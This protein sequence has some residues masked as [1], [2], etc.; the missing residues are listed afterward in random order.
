M[1]T[2]LAFLDAL[3]AQ[4]QALSSAQLIFATLALVTTTYLV[5]YVVYQR[6]FHPLAKFPGPFCASITNFWKVYELSTLAL[7]TRM[8][9]VHEKYGPVVRI[10]PDDLSFNIP[11]AIAPIYKVGRK[12]P[13]GI[14]Y[15]GY[16]STVPD[17]FST[18]DENVSCETPTPGW[19]VHRTLLTNEFNC[20]LHALRLKQIGPGLSV[21]ALKH[22]EPV[23]DN[24]IDKLLQK[25]DGYVESGAVLD[26]KSALGLYGYDVTAQLAF[27]TDFKAQTTGELPPLN[28][29]F[30][31]GNIYGL[32]ANLLPHIA[33]WSAYL[34]QVK[35]LIQSRNDLKKIAA[36]SI[37]QSLETHNNETE[38]GTLLAAL[39][40]A[41]DPDSGKGLTENEINSEAFVFLVAGSHTT[42]SAMVALLFYI[43]QNPKVLARVRAELDSAIPGQQRTPYE[44]TGL[45][46][47]L[48]YILACIRESFRMSPTAALL[49]P[50]EVINPAGTMIGDYHVPLGA[51]CS[52]L[53]TCLHH[54]PDVWGSDH[55]QFDPDRFLPGSARYSSSNPNM[56]F[57]FGQGNRQ[58]A[59]R[60]IALMSIWKVVVT[61]MKNY[62]IELVNPNE[63]FVML[64]YGVG[65]KKGPMNVRVKRRIVS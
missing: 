46:T 17:I 6:Y 45:E 52:I 1:A 44:F 50:H 37:R 23:F 18:R 55:N 8:C 32:L 11:Q 20:Q 25:L 42:S 7:P 30:L 56:L 19:Y 31:L 47:N 10:G 27:D 5:G 39:I 58:C 53:S 9:A 48:P 51:N 29:H 63:E 38:P 62:D 2:K 14:F 40:N 61:V 35:A 24:H 41:K 36:D 4:T 33:T 15:K 16:V 3:R 22:M 13:K 26:L 43:H 21:S 28:N 64:E 49:L 60:N 65:D 12:M 59:G 57:H 34:P 54:N